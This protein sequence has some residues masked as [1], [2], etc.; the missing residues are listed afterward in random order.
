VAGLAERALERSQRAVAHAA[1]HVDDH[2][3]AECCLNVRNRDRAL[4][5]PL[6]DEHNAA[7][8]LAA[9]WSDGTDRDHFEVNEPA[10]FDRSWAAAAA[11]GGVPCV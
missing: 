4:V 2:S 7:N 8:E 11:E 9:R 10:D 6:I 5:A 3:A 1:S